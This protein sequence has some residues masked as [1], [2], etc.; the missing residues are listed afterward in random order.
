MEIEYY[1]LIGIG[2][3][4]IANVIFEFLGYGMNKVTGEISISPLREFWKTFLREGGII[5]NIS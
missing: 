4:I 1:I 5:V 3:G 2:I